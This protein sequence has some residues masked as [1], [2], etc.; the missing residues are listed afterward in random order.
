ML[1]PKT[2][3]IFGETDD[4][5]KSSLVNE[6]GISPLVASLLIN[7]G[8]Q[9]PQDVQSFLYDQGQD[10]H[11][12][13]LLLGMDLA[14]ARIK[15]AIDR[16]EP[17]LI[18][19]DYDCDGVTSTSVMMITLRELGANVQFYIPNRFTEGYGP[20]EQAFKYAAEIGVRLIIT[21][22]TGIAA[23]HEAKVAAEL[24]IDLIITDHHESGPEL[25]V[26]LAI[27]HPKLPDSPYPFRDLAGV[28]V[29]FKL[30]HAL[31]GD[32][33]EHLLELAAIGTIADL[34]PLQG[35]NRLIAKKGIKKLRSTERIGLR[36]LLKQAG[37]DSSSINEETIGY[38]IGPRINAVGRLESADR[39]VD[40]LLTNDPFEAESIAEEIESLNKERQGIVSSIAEEAMKEVEEKYPIKEN[41]VIVVGKQG[42]NAGV[43]GIVA[44]KLVER[45]YRPAIVLSFDEEKGLAKGSARSIEGFDLFSNLSTCRDILPHFGG[46]PMAAGMTLEISDVNE[47][48]TRLNNLAK[49]QLTEEDFI[50]VTKL[51]S[52]ID[53]EEIDLASLEEMQ[54]LAPFGVSNP[55][56]KILLSGSSISQIRRIGA[57]GNHLKITLN[58]QGKALDG[59]GFGLGHL[60][61]EISPHSKVSVIGEL[62]INEW[63]NIRKPQIF[64]QDIAVN[65]WQLFDCRGQNLKEIVSKAKWIVFNDKDKLN[66]ENVI[67]IQSNEEAK[68]LNI[69]NENIVLVDFPPSKEIIEN[70]FSGKKPGRVYVHFY[71]KDSDFFSTMPTREHFKWFYGFLAKKAPF[72]LK[73]YGNELAKYRGWSIETV[74]FMS[75]VFLELEFINFKDG[76]ITLNKVVNRRDLSQSIT[77]QQKQAHFSLE[78]ELLYS[79]FQQLKDW[80][81]GLIQS[82]VKFE[83]AVGEWI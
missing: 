64:L 23:I 15:E 11:D 9:S 6:L 44:S 42:W 33:P 67:H 10:F 32:I 45:F 3:W 13:Y 59:V 53:L 80:F 18:F 50:P 39:A 76:Y 68:E 49:E 21:V 19:G 7:R 41:A 43:I 14:V 29:A 38:M 75:Q 70:L 60:F 1:K 56:P 30:A 40:L 4:E 72:D 54:M 24:G 81:D 26:A 36:A 35:E 28:G 46:H 55:K 73:R 52:E 2:R 20:N 83:E 63:N 58:N 25:P 78:S 12:P 22:D 69:T 74:N 79:S 37:A 47:L 34:V 61:E 5:K 62:S 8:I 27:I 51:D 71:K 31:Y 82:S 66:K 77:Y 17:I 48:R 16:K 65:E 57:D